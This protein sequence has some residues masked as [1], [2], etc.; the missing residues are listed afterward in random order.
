MDA[1]KLVD[2]LRAMRKQTAANLSIGQ[3]LKK[4]EQFNDDARLFLSNDKFFT[5]EFGS[6]RGYY[7]DMYIGY[8]DTDTGL[9]TVGGL[10]GILEAALAKGEMKGY[11]GG[12]FP[13]DH[14]TLL[15]MSSY[16]EVD[17]WA[18]VDVVKVGDA[19]VVV[20]KDDEEV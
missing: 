12:D 5:T 7:E 2:A 11:K 3:M 19:I 4:L 1:Q 16:G 10:R 20:A 8:S 6:Y 13:I 17:G 14:D 9:N 15:W 18:L